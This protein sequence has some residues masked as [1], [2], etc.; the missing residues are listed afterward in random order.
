MHDAVKDTLVFD[1][2][3]TKDIPDH[4]SDGHVIF[5]ESHEKHHSFQNTREDEIDLMEHL[6]DPD[7]AEGMQDDLI[8]LCGDSRSMGNSV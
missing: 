8:N 3:E 2:V 7:K 1:A 6:E 4:T 5:K